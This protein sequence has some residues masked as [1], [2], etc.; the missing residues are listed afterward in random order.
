VKGQPLH[1]HEINAAS[2]DEEKKA[3]STE[4]DRSLAGA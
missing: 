3:N 1:E 4:R 2:G